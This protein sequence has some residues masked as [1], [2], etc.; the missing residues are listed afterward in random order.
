MNFTL[1]QDEYFLVRRIMLEK[2]KAE[3]NNGDFKFADIVRKIRE[4]T[5]NEYFE[6]K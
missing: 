5:E 3:I 4:K 1:T 6:Q 2:E